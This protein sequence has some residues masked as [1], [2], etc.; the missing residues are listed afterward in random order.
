MYCGSIYKLVNN[1]DLQKCAAEVDFNE[2]VSNRRAA[3]RYCFVN[4]N[5]AG[6]GNAGRL[7]TYDE[8]M[9]RN[10]ELTA[11]CTR[12]LVH[13]KGPGFQC[14]LDH[15]GDKEAALLLKGTDE[16][17]APLVK[18]D[19]APGLPASMKTLW[20]A[21]DR[22]VSAGGA[23]GSTAAVAPSATLQRPAAPAPAAPQPVPASPQVVRKDRAAPTQQNMLKLQT[24][25][26]EAAKQFPGG[27]ASDP[28]GYQKAVTA[29]LNR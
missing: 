3:L 24:C 1:A 11:L 28:A 9:N 15:P 18:A 23:T 20:A 22:T 14:S 13:S 4:N 19:T 25:S 21:R 6:A 5:Y 17:G 2:L 26:Q 12:E 27:I 8:C 16:N 29:C 7:K 10:D